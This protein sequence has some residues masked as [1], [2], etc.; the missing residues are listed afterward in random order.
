MEC[1]DIFMRY[2]L[3]ASFSPFSARTMLTFSMSM[4]EV[5]SISTTLKHSELTSVPA[6]SL[7]MDSANSPRSF[8]DSREDS[9]DFALLFLN[10]MT[11]LIAPENMVYK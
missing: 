8:S 4:S 3:R 6:T 7:S 1:D 10:G 5:V 2:S 11:A 9:L